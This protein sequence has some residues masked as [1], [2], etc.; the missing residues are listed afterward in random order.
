[1]GITKAVT[2]KDVWIP[3]KASKNY[4]LT[5]LQKV[6][7]SLYAHVRIVVENTIAKAKSFFILRVENRMRKKAKMTTAFQICVALANLK[8]EL[9][10]LNT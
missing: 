3:F 7:N 10:I 6:I 9:F 2:C 8:T 1:M 4:P 5:K